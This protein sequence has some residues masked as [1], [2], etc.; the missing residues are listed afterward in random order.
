MNLHLQR[1][2]LLSLAFFASSLSVDSI[3]YAASSVFW[4]SDPIR[5]GE[6]AMLIGEGFGDKPTVEI[7]KL[8]DGTTR[9]PSFKML[10]WPGQGHTAEELQPNDTSVKFV[11]PSSLP[12][13]IYT[14]RITAQSGS[15][16]GLLNRPTVW[17]AQGDLGTTATPG[18]WLRLFGKCLSSPS[19]QME[20][21]GV[22]RSTILLQGPRTLTLAAD[23]DCYTA[24]ASLPKDLPVGD[25]RVY[26]H[27]GFGGDQG[28][29]EGLPITIRRPTPW[30]TTIFNVRDFG[31]DGTGAKDDTA[32]VQSALAKAQSSG[33]GVVYF[34]R[35][36]YQITE[37]L[38]VPRLTTLR[39]EE[40]ELV[41]L[42]WP[43]IQKPPDALVKGTNSFAIEDVTLYSSNHRH[44]IVGDL[45]DRP[46]A[47]HVFLRRVRVRADAYRG[48]LKAEEVDARF[49]A[50]QSIGGGDTVRL[51]GE[52][53]EITGC[54][55]YGSGRA[56]FLSRVRGGLVSDNS[57]YNGRWGWYCISGSDGLIFE[58][59]NI[60]GGDLMATGGGLN[61]LDGSVSSQKVYYAHNHLRLMHGWDREAMTSDAGGEV[62]FGKIGRADGTTLILP[63]AP[64]WGR[65][66]K[67]G[68]VFILEGKGA[69]QFRRVVS[70][71]DATVELDRPW[72]AAPDDTSVVSVT[73]FQGYY[74]LVGNDFTDTGAMQF[75]GTSI[76]CIVAENEGTRM[77]GFRGLGLWYHGYQPSWYCQFLDNHIREGN[78]YHWSSAEDSYVEVYGAVRPPLKGPLC[79][80]AVL[81]RNTLDN[82]AHIQIGG[83][84]QDVVAEGNS[85]EHSAIGTFVSGQSTNIL[86]RNNHYSDVKQKSVDEASL[87]RMAEERGKMFFG[88]KEPV[89]TWSFDA[90][91]GTR[92]P[93]ISGN[94][95]HAT[96]NGGVK[97]A[98]DG[99]RGQAVSFDGTG[100]L[101]VGDPFVF[102]APDLTISF[103]IKPSVVTGRRGLISKRYNGAEAPFVVNQSAAT[104]GFEAT[105]ENGPWTFNFQGPAV[106]KLNEWTHIAI[107]VR[108]GEGVA[109]YANGQKVAEKKNDTKRALNN[110]P[111][112]LGREAW[113]GDPPKGETPGF[114]IGLMDEVKIWTRTLT[115]EEIRA[116]STR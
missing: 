13:G 80:G 42:L 22:K 24:R 79:R 111:L 82:N 67:G 108:Q 101:K 93:D 59:N 109:I 106:L 35:G 45:G 74:L 33:G 31:A 19:A 40:R 1:R 21:S 68:A 102:N 113:G 51:G 75:Y 96:V 56:L 104:V 114:F 23:A 6:T 62:Y 15:C 46:E 71:H 26:L 87:R 60:I 25:Y 61:C 2:I 112:I 88:R 5:P 92:F 57:F 98:P 69:G 90:M 76:E 49:R 99:V 14:Y 52:N 94:G 3:S 110:E 30:P 36:R 7:A 37:T 48:H 70:T 18:G 32:A 83:V 16:V 89:A 81:R 85:V 65:D 11:I 20:R 54:D 9:A 66:W 10:S 55:F 27:S 115:P 116:E 29:S 28:W 12:P 84:C 4:A 53:I 73:M 95:F 63:A 105:Q 38:T 39:G 34:P 107:V 50:A 8:T 78:Y 58:K 43:D 17:W 41:C 91:Q 47:G 86:L 64:S 97:A 77:Q 103:W 72:A 100:Y 44:I